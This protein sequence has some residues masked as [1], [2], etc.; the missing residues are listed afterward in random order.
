MPTHCSRN[1]ALLGSPPTTLLSVSPVDA[2]PRDSK[3]KMDGIS[4]NT[5]QVLPCVQLS[6]GIQL[7][8]RWC[9]LKSLG[10]GIRH[11]WN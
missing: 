3:R 11:V 5:Y 1:G 4:T 7:G 9:R 10:L 6:A 2:C 8:E